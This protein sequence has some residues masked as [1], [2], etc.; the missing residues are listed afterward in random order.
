MYQTFL[1]SKNKRISAPEGLTVSWGRWAQFQFGLAWNEDYENAQSR[2]S[3]NLS[4][5][6]RKGLPE[7]RIP[8]K[9]SEEWECVCPLGEG[10]K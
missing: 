8:E 5:E 4:G 7:E 10:L 2:I 9:V 3:I 6:A 1:G